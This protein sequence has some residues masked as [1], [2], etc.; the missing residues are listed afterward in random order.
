M[1]CRLGSVCWLLLGTLTLRYG[2]EKKAPA[3]T[4]TGQWEK[5]DGLQCKAAAHAECTC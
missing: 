1:V 5:T 3:F 4:W 2:E